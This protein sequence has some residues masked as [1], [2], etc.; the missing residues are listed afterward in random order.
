MS[1]NTSG[2]LLNHIFTQTE[3][4]ISFLA[5]QNY[6]SSQDATDILTR[7]NTAHSRASSDNSS[8]ANS[9]QALAL[10]PSPAVPPPARRGVPPPPQP[11]LT[12]AKA[13][14][15][16]NEDGRVRTVINHSV[17]IRAHHTLCRSRMICL[18][19]RVKL[20]RLW[21]R[22]TQTGGQGSAEVVKGCFLPITQKKSRL[23]HLRPLPIL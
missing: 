6:I 3:A 1:G 15:G 11:R 13:I 23:G 19:T 9:M 18:S 20:S 21:K 2:A 7:L 14:W 17:I 10:A 12:Q 16:Y 4:N 5:S 8:I 22:T